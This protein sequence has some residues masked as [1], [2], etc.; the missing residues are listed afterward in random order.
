MYVLCR[1]PVSPVSCVCSVC[2]SGPVWVTHFPR[3]WPLIGQDFGQER[4]DCLH[5]CDSAAVQTR[6][7]HAVSCFV[8]RVVLHC[9]GHKG[10][11]GT[12]SKHS[13]GSQK[14]KS[15]VGSWTG[16]TSQFQR[17]R[18]KPGK[19]SRKHDRV[20]T[21]VSCPFLCITSSSY[22]VFA[23]AL[24]SYETLSSPLV[25]WSRCDCATA[26]KDLVAMIDDKHRAKGGRYLLSSQ[27]DSQT[28]K[29]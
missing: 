2:C 18:S 4:S 23:I 15:G 28:D 21:Q 25:F 27:F 26:M 12:Q 5:V 10:L 1:L 20:H 7:V 13:S 19:I 14:S 9:S 8:H 24:S 16:G 3:G 29:C 22:F 6:G 17:F 11:L